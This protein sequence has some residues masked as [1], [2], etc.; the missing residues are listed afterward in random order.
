MYIWLHKPAYQIGY[1]LFV[2]LL[3]L[4]LPSAYALTTDI[5][6]QDVRSGV[7]ASINLGC[8]WDRNTSAMTFIA[9]YSKDDGFVSE[10]VQPYIYADGDIMYFVLSE[11]QFT[12][13]GYALHHV[14]IEYGE[15]FGRCQSSSIPIS[16]SNN[17]GLA[18][19][20]IPPPFHLA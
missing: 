17:A 11:D 7:P 2:F 18:Y 9:Y 1:L 19:L 10:E 4:A 16:T 3:C 12:Y 8:S 13:E 14:A 15:T 6:A 20:A 5:L